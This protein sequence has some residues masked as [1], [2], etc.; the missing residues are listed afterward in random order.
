M[1]L[2]NSKLGLFMLKALCGSATTEEILFFL[3]LNGKCY[4]TQLKKCLQIALTPIQKSLARLEKEGIVT[5][6]YEGR[7]RVYTFNPAYPLLSELEALIKKAYL[8]LP[9]QIKKDYSLAEEYDLKQ[10][11]KKREI[12]KAFWKKLERIGQLTVHAKSKANAG[13]WNGKGHAQVTL[14]K[15][16]ETVLIFQ[17]KGTW[18]N[19]LTQFSNAFRWILDMTSG[20]VSL[21]HLRHGIQNPVF[22]FHLTPIDKYTLKSINSHCCGEDNYLGQLYFDDLTIRFNW[23]VIGPK[24]NE[25]LDFY[26]SYNY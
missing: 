5:S 20:S 22:L 18:E 11:I 19:N 26:Y 7:T 13:G 10:L 15:E 8:L 24:K 23:R 17:E 21:E 9:P 6:Y 12:L 3:F 16:K 2:K 14:T 4:G 25:V 1:S